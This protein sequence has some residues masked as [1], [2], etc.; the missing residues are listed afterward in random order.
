MTKPLN[1]YI[2][3]TLLKPDASASDITRLCREALEYDFY[4]VCV[5]GCHV[6][7]A[8]SLL[9][10]SDVKIAAVAGF[11][12]GAMSTPAKL[13]EMSQALAD[14]ADEIDLVMNIGAFKEKRHEDVLNEVSAAAKLCHEHDALLKLIIETCLLTRDEIGKACQ[15]A[16][17]AGADFVKTSTGFSTGGAAVSDIALMREAVCGKA[18]LK[19][20]GGIRSYAFA[21]ALINEGADRLGCSASIAIIQESIE[22]SAP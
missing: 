7:L 5:N 4:S 2:D 20:A 17:N 8:K 15:I 9:A 6:P 13:F 19:A 12:L 14:G 18:Q 10:G 21:R 3:H 11:P 1:K 22:N 16:V